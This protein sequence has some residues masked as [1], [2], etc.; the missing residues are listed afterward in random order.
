MTNKDKFY[1][2]YGN[3]PLNLRDEI[4]IVIDKE[5]I[6][7]KVARLEIENNTK[8]GNII[9]NKLEELKII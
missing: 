6:S 4:I 7:W 9:L 2:V 8:Q 1:K 3:L 5:P